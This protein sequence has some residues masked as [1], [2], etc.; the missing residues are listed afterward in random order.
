MPI[1]SRCWPEKSNEPGDESLHCGDI[2]Y[3]SNSYNHAGSVGGFFETGDADSGFISR[4]RNHS[5]RQQQS[6]YAS[7][8][9]RESC[10]RGCSKFPKWQ[11]AIHADGDLQQTTNSCHASASLF[12]AKLR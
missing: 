4:R 6:S 8:H 1:L 11:S 10:E 7:I 9:H 2:W 5:V 12:R 3:V